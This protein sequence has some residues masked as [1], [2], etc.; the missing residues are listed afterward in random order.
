MLI[1]EAVVPVLADQDPEI[2]A[3]CPLM[4]RERARAMVREWKEAVE[5]KASSPSSVPR[6]WEGE[7]VMPVGDSAMGMKRKILWARQRPIRL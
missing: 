6:C 2:S 1:L 5:K 4:A 3:A 7:N